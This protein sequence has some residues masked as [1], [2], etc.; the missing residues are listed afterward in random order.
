[1]LCM[2]ELFGQKRQHAFACCGQA[3]RTF[4]FA[5]LFFSASS[6]ISLVSERRSIGAFGFGAGSIG[7][8]SD[9]DSDLAAQTT[10]E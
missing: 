4:F 8:S 2:D 1:M 9:S 6:A 10:R 5:A 7:A 3:S